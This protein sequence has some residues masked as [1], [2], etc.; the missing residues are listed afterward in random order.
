MPT[1]D[2]RP[3]RSWSTHLV[4]LSLVAAVAAGACGGGTPAEGTGG[5]TGA[6]GSAAGTGGSSAGTGG[7]VVAGSASYHRST[8]RLVEGRH[9]LE[10]LTPEEADARGLTPCRICHPEATAGNGHRTRAR[11]S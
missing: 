5:S 8:C 7:T 11:A 4:L 10:I 9:D 3:P 2:R 6:G 1:C